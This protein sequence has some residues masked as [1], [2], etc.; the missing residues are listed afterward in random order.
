MSDKEYRKIQ[1]LK[2]GEWIETSHR[3]LK[4]DDLFKMFETDGTLL[5]NADGGFIFR[6]LS[7]IHIENYDDPTSDWIELE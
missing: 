2:D 3:E 7:D 6:A 4:K 1:I 5:E